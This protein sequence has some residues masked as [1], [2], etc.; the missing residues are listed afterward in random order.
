MKMSGHIS[1]VALHFLDILNGILSQK[2][3]DIKTIIDLILL[4]RFNGEQGVLEV[5]NAA[6]KAH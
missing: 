4:R 3:F 5:H 2:E 1:Q 6:L